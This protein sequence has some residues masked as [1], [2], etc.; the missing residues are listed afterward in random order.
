MDSL[1]AKSELSLNEYIVPPTPGMELVDVTTL[2]LLSDNSHN[3]NSYSSSGNQLPK[4][5]PILQSSKGNAISISSIQSGRRLNA[6]SSM[7]GTLNNNNIVDT[8]S[9]IR[10]GDSGVCIALPDG[11]IAF[12][13]S[14][15][16]MVDAVGIVEEN[17]QILMSYPTVGCG[18]VTISDDRTAIG[19]T[20]SYLACCLRGGTCYLLPIVPSSSSSSSS[21]TTT[22]SETSIVQQETDDATNN[23]PSISTFQFPHD[24]ASDLPYTY[25]RG[26]TAGNL[27]LLRNVDSHGSQL[28]H[29]VLVFAWPGGVVD[30]YVCGLLPTTTISSMC[31]GP[32]PPPLPTQNREGT[33]TQSAVGNFVPR[34]ERQALED[35]IDNE[36]IYLLCEILKEQLRK[37]SSTHPVV[38]IS[39]EVEDEWKTVL[40]NP[41]LLVA[42]NSGVLDID[43]LCTDEFRPVRSLLLTLADN[44]E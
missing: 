21:G 42:L 9:S 24:V 30:V 27:Q 35:M 37:E 14:N 3:S 39:T 11:T 2:P 10:G 34:E 8:N 20:T 36:S 31:D 32:S 17:H 19:V 7:D 15:P 5:F 13:S 26:F 41:T 28:L 1:I 33:T 25:V 16:T 43:L 22:N 18:V 29:P 12:L 23:H 40:Q 6:S 4:R 38:H 44:T